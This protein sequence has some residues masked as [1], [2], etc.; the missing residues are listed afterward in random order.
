MTEKSLRLMHRRIGVPL[1]VFIVIQSVTGVILAIEDIVSAYWGGP[2]HDL[3]FGFD[4]AGHV[5][6]IV[7]GAGL[8]YMA[9]TGVMI[10]LRIRART[11]RQGS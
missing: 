2:V 8:L 4:L 10:Y 3:H 6:R 5:Y 9:A 1:A 11:K 7:L